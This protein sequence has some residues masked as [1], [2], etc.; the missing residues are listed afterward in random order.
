MRECSGAIYTFI[1]TEEATEAF[2]YDAEITCLVKIV[3]YLFVILH[4]IP[5]IFYLFITYSICFHVI[6]LDHVKKQTHTDTLNNYLLSIKVNTY[7]VL[8]CSSFLLES[9]N[10]YILLF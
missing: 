1:L 6:R 2:V 4:K 3:C 5:T 9:Q 7:H 8:S 10:K